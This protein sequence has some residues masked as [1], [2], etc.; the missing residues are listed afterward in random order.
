M[1]FGKCH[2]SVVQIWA[3]NPGA[4][5]HMGQGMQGPGTK[6]GTQKG[7]G[8]GSGPFHAPFLGPR[9]GP[10]PLGSLAHMIPGPWVYKAEA[11]ICV[12]YAKNMCRLCEK[13]V[14]Y[15]ENMYLP[16]THHPGSPQAKTKPARPRPL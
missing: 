2:V 3:G 15:A 11:Y 5:E 6:H 12:G 16:P 14:G 10:W 7:R 1:I 9:L 8:P 4:R 13:Y